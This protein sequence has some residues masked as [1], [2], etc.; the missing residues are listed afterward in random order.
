MFALRVILLWLIT[1]SLGS[2]IYP[3]V[4]EKINSFWKKIYIL[5]ILF[6]LYDTINYVKIE[7][8]TVHK[9]LIFKYTSTQM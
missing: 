6:I 9:I 5:W 1:D 2:K 8:D 4:I 3:L 7:K